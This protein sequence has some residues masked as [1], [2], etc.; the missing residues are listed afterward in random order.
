[1]A[2]ASA[3]MYGIPNCGTIKKARAWLEAAGIDYDFHDYKKQGVD[4]QLLRGWVRQFGW[5]QVIN[6]RG[7]TW[8]KLDEAMR[9]S[10]DENSAI[11]IMQEKHSIIKRPI[12]TTADQVLLGFD[13]ASYRRAFGV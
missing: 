6:R 13:E 10:M 4:E 3:V 8:R 11:R 7:M 9:E 2:A 1:M 5:E 12:V